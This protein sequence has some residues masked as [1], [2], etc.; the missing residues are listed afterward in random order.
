[1]NFNELNMFKFLDFKGKVN[2]DKKNVDRFERE[3]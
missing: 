2:Y 3:E 1:M